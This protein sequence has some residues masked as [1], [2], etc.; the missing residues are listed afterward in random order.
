[1]LAV[2]LALVVSIVAVA[3]WGVGMARQRG[4][5]GPMVVPQEYRA[6]IREAAQRCPRVPANV[7]AAQIAAESS[8]D[9]RAESPV[10]ARGIAQF[11]P[12]V[13]RQYGIDANGDGKRSV[14]DPE[15]AIHSAAELNCLN[16]KLVR[17]VPGNRLHNTL[18]AYNAG[19]GNVIKYGGV[20]PFPETEAYLERILR[21]AETIRLSDAPSE[22][23][24]P[25]TRAA[26]GPASPSPRG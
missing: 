13:W 21:Y 8:W 5:I 7:F 1:M 20:P 11:M 26:E 24:G 14:W 16:R 6:L 4:V 10:G 25:A 2:V 22:S 17:D 19:H 3:W 9:P 12:K 18:A 23:Q 15:D